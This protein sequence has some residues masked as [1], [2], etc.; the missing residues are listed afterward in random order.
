MVDDSAFGD[1]TLDTCT[2]ITLPVEIVA[3]A[4]DTDCVA[5]DYAEVY[6]G[7]DHDMV[8][9]GASPSYGNN[10]NLDI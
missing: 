9:E 7:D 10:N 2:P 1:G 3:G 6:F 5:L 4:G 8:I